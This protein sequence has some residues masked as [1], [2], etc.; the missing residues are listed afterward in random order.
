MS[1]DSLDQFGQALRGEYD[2]WH[3][4]VMAFIWRLLN[5]IEEAPELMLAMQLLF[6]WLSCYL[7]SIS[8]RST[9]WRIFIF[10]LFFTAPF[11]HNFAGWVLKDI[12]MAFS[13]LLALAILFNYSKRDKNNEKSTA[14]RPIWLIIATSFQDPCHQQAMRLGI[15]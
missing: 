2:D 4:P 7:F 6:L 1:P 15:R 5:K 12:V 13:W 8:I 10:I 9:I 11:I 14:K 3:P